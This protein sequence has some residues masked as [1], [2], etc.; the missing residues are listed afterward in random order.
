[1][2]CLFVL[3]IIPFVVQK[4]LSFTGLHLI[5]FVFIPLLGR[6]LEKDTVAIYVKVSSAYVFLQEFY[7]MCSYI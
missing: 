2:C 5:I 1:M 3:F 6:L 7:S 4:A